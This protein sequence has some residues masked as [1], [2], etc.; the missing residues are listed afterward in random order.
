MNSSNDLNNPKARN[1]SAR[2][3]ATILGREQVWEEQERAR[4]MRVDAYKLSLAR[5]YP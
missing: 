2:P 4:E 5:V 3:K 1:L